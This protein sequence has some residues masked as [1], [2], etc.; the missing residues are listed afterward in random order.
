M[1]TPTKRNSKTNK[2]KMITPTKSKFRS[3]FTTNNLSIGSY[4]ATYIATDSIGNI[5]INYRTLNITA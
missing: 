4:T 1:I 2:E 3:P 5:G